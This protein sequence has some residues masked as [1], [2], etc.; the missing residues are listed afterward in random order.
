[1]PYAIDL[2]NTALKVLHQDP[3]SKTITRLHQWVLT[4]LDFTTLVSQVL[5]WVKTLPNEDSIAWVSTNPT[6]ETPLLKALEASHPLVFKTLKPLDKR[7]L[8]N[9]SSNGGVN[10]TY[11][12]ASWDSFGLDRVL[13]LW[14]YAHQHPAET[15][16]LINAGTC[17]TVDI[18][19]DGNHY[20]GGIILPGVEAWQQAMP[21]QA[22]HLPLPLALSVTASFLPPSTTQEAISQGVGYPYAMGILGYV[23]QV[24]RYWQTPV[25][26]LVVTGGYADWLHHALKVSL[27]LMPF[28][29]DD[30]K[31]LALPTVILNA[32]WVEQAI[33]TASAFQHPTP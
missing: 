16:L 23:Q 7:A 8:L 5:A 10:F 19:V 33:F 6:L 17:T 25:V 13:N 2:G 9:A 28:N 1:M 22:P 32:Q 4:T 15:G 11:Y 3:T 14:H 18:L 12:R 27:P 29:D 21:S 20:G 24:A 30:D 26:K 31:A